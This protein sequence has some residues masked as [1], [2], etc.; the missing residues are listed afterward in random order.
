MSHESGK[1]RFYD[2]MKDLFRHKISDITQYLHKR[3]G[4]LAYLKQELEGTPVSSSQDLERLSKR[5]E[6]KEAHCLPFV[7][8]REAGFN[9][10][11]L[12]CE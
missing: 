4:V 6:R 12:E 9:F 1:A 7:G 10:T 3:A 5:L 11:R 8:S 2:F